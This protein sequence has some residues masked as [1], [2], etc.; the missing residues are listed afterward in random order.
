MLLHASIIGKVHV[1]G[2]SQLTA[3]NHVQLTVCKKGV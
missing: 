3:G 1:G 2:Y